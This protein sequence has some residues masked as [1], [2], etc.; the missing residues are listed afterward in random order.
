MSGGPTDLRKHC[1]WKF[2]GPKNPGSRI[3]TNLQYHW[4]KHIIWLIWS[5][6]NSFLFNISS[7][8][9]T[10]FQLCAQV[11]STLSH[12]SFY[13]PGL[14][15]PP[16]ASS[17]W[18]VCPFVCLFSSCSQSDSP[19]LSLSRLILCLILSFAVFLTPSCLCHCLCLS[20]VFWHNV[21]LFYPCLFPVMSLESFPLLTRLSDQPP[22]LQHFS[23]LPRFRPDTNL[24]GQP[25]IL[26][27]KLPL[28]VKMVL[29]K[30]M[31]HWV[32]E[33]PLPIQIFI[34]VKRMFALWVIA[35]V[36]SKRI[37]DQDYLR[38]HLRKRKF[39]VKLTQSL[40]DSTSPMSET[41]KIQAGPVKFQNC[42]PDWACKIVESKLKK[43]CAKQTRIPFF[44]SKQGQ[45]CRS[46]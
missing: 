4:I 9:Y 23:F 22:Q 6:F 24:M 44:K 37:T 27:L 20:A 7:I 31:R 33:N 3:I 32:K 13:A 39:A 42:K 36:L 38:A 11:L 30:W 28:N 12:F 17:V 15:G 43:Y 16:G 46:F 5:N 2:A 34:S 35:E 41:C 14:K 19:S 8:D 29:V 21:I 40:K 1:E 45:I 26:K 10:R 25:S 18:I